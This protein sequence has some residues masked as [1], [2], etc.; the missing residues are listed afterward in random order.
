MSAAHDLRA[1]SA[2]AAA[3]LTAASLAAGLLMASPATAD[4]TDTQPPSAVPVVAPTD[5]SISGSP[6]VGSTLT[7]TASPWQPVD[8]EITVAWF[9][10]GVEIVEKEAETSDLDLALTP[11]FAGTRITAE[12]TGQAAGF[13]SSTVSLTTDADVAVGTIT[14]GV[15]VITGVP[16]VGSVLRSTPGRWEPTPKLGYQWLRAGV[17]IAGATKSTYK[18]APADRGSRISVRVSA[19]LVGYAPAV[20]VSTPTSSVL[21]V[22][23]ASPVPRILGPRAVGAT[24]RASPGT[25]SPAAARSYQWYRNGSP[26]KGATAATYVAK[27]PDR[28]KKLTVRVTGRRT[29]YVPL[30]RSSAA[31]SS[32]RSALS[33][34]NPASAS[35]LVNKHRAL[36]PKS[37]VPTGMIAPRVRGG[38]YLMK[39]D[40]ARALERLFAGARAAKAGEMSLA[41]GYRSYATQTQIFGRFVAERGRKAAETFSARPGH[42]EHQT[43]FAA[44]IA[45]CG[46][47]S[48]R[49]I[50]EFGASKQSA[51]VSENAW[52][53]GFVIRYVRSATT[54]TGYTAEPWH[55]RFIGTTLAREYDA[56]GFTSLERFLGAPAAPSYR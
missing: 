52:R 3:V 4:D 39:K 47:R 5:A 51:W 16:R 11:A 50:G 30:S 28:G 9:A 27:I 36:S 38:G 35:V 12:L 40:A 26:I 22:F 56:G 7:I 24:L 31:T 17:V 54:V 44:D 55:L 48:C 29:G 46:A 53:Y 20:R 49:A 1:L 15:P 13:E 25:W 6:M 19:A 14:T 43:G 10:D 42:S 23:A 21:G 37:Y 41:S 8:T 45:A 34:R 18:L 32:L 2:R 33:I